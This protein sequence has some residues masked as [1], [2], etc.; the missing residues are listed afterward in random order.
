MPGES[1]PQSALPNGGEDQDEESQTPSQ[2]YLTRDEWEEIA[3]CL[4]ALKAAIDS[5]QELE[6]DGP[7]E[8]VRCV[9]RRFD[10]AVSA[11]EQRIYGG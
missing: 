3:G 9:H 11:V 2:I 1:L 6:R 5:S 4:F 8:L 7:A 10:E